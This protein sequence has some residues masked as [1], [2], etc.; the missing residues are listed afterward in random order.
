MCA[1]LETGIEREN[2]SICQRQRER[3]GRKRREED[4][5][6]KTEDEEE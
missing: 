3:V 4:L 5:G 2:H 1:G 6:M